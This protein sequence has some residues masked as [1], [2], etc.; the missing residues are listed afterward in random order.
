MKKIINKILGGSCLILC[1]TSCSESFFDRE[2]TSDIS[3]KQLSENATWN[4]NIMLGQFSSTISSTF[5]FGIGGLSTDEDFGQ[6]SVDISTDL[7]SGD[8]VMSGETYGW[9]S[10][11]SKLLNSTSSKNKDY[12]IWRY[13]YKMIYAANLIFDTNGGDKIAPSQDSP[14]RIYYAQAKVMRAYA[15]LNLVNLYSANYESSKDVPCIP[16]YTSLKEV[17]D[18]SMSERPDATAAPLST[19]KE[20][21]KLIIS[22]LGE[23]SVLLDGYVRNTKDK[24]NKSVAQ[25]LLAYAYLSRG[26]SGDY[27]LAAKN[28]QSVIANGDFSLMTPKEIVESGFNNISI[29][30]WI[31]GVDITK[32]NT[33][34]L[35][36]FWG[37][38]DYFTYSYCAAGD[39]KMIPDNLY[40]QIPSSDSRKGWFRTKAPLMA[41]N[42]FYDSARKAMGNKTWDND[43]VFMRIEEMYLV[44]AESCLRAGDLVKA[45]EYLKTFLAQR[46]VTVMNSLDQKNAAELLD[47]IYY[48]WRVEMWG[49]GRGL[50]TMKRFK[51]SVVRGTNDF[52]YPGKTISYDDN[53][54]VFQLPDNEIVNNTNIK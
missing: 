4:P 30:S 26:E 3:D 7:M 38:M 42:K 31:W 43:I 10:A 23:A 34:G 25:G 41:I 20:I 48:N 35:A 8:I 40:A 36:S 18:A 27:E 47:I 16:V 14:N 24:P 15:Y 33:G 28:S 45:K 46:D 1:L 11:D 12:M 32:S 53:R 54:L 44:S 50:L 2:P 6:K 29:K 13:Y 5:K 22:D 51:K 17:S 21:Y 52:A 19:P 39:Y 49:E 9:F 37:Q